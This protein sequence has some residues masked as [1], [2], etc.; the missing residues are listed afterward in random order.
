MNIL[1][2]IFVSTKQL[3]KSATEAGEVDSTPDFATT[4]SQLLMFVSSRNC[5]QISIWEDQPGQALASPVSH[6][7]RTQSHNGVVC[8][9]TYDISSRI[10]LESP[11]GRRHI[12]SSS[13]LNRLPF[14]T[15]TH[16]KRCSSTSPKVGVGQQ[17]CGWSIAIDLILFLFMFC[18]ILIWIVLS[19]LL[20]LFLFFCFFFAA[21]RT[22][23]GFLEQYSWWESLQGK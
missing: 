18:F 6:Q 20:L 13:C 17:I 22:D 1:Y 16:R 5:V 3:I 23:R 14:V 11:W 7:C 15:Y 8:N 12:I 10:V 9:E 4:D 21:Q 2:E 19:L